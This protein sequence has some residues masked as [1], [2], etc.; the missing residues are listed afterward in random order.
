[1]CAANR[2][3]LDEFRPEIY[4]ESD[5]RPPCAALGCPAGPI[6]AG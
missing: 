1:M 3:V 6:D 5:K 4:N 2:N